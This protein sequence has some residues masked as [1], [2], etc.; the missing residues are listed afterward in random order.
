MKAAIKKSNEFQY[1]AG[2]AITD[3]IK[4]TSQSKLLLDPE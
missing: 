4:E 2:L 1:N 3:T